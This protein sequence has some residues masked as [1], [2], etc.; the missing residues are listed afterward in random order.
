ME[1]ETEN[2]IP[3]ET[4]DLEEL[5]ASVSQDSSLE[6]PVSAEN[7]SN[8]CQKLELRIQKDLL[9]QFVK[10]IVSQSGN[11][12]RTRMSYTEAKLVFNVVDGIRARVVDPAHVSLVETYIAREVF[13]S[14]WYDPR[15]EIG[16]D[17]DL[18]AFG[19]DMDKLDVFLKTEK[20]KD[21]IIELDLDMEKRKMTVKG[22]TGIRV[23]SLIDVT[24]MCDPKQPD[25]GDKLH[26]KA[27]IADPKTFRQQLKS[28]DPVS[29]HVA[30]RFEYE[31]RVLYLECEGDM[32]KVQCLVSMDV[33]RSES[34]TIES[35]DSEGNV[36]RTQSRNAR[37]LFPLEYLECIAKAIPGAFS[38]EIGN[39][40]PLRISYGK[41]VFM[42]APRIE[43]GD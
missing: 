3:E 42:L 32:D 18:L 36:Q 19:V 11:G 7:E 20:T 6:S 38:L 4:R 5:Q 10:E 34:A 1:Q 12:R 43:S 8:E 17:G 31:T 28:M 23:M 25:L 39:D 41:T 9:K 24:G 15:A 40:Y 26:F 29:D 21:A 16:T 22:P 14:V 37:S 27:Y 13:D 33:E 30:I 2:V 35:W